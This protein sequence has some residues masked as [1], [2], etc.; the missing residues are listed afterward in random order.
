MK[1]R[2]KSQYFDHLPI[3]AKLTLDI[4]LSDIASSIVPASDVTFP[5]I[6]YQWVKATDVDVDNY[7]HGTQSAL[8]HFTIPKVVHCNNEQHRHHIDMYY[9][10]RPICKVLASVGKLTV[11]TNKFKRSQDFIVPGFNEHLKELHC[12]ARAQYL[13]WSNDSNSRTGESHRDV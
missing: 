8:S 6:N 7:R 10:S 3:Y 1:I 2:E 9:D 13:I 4:G 5:A 11:P 12:E